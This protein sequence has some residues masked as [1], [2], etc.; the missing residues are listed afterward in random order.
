[1]AKPVYERVKELQNKWNKPVHDN[2]VER[3][4]GR[5]AAKGDTRATGH[6]EMSE[7]DT[8][9]NPGRDDVDAAQLYQDDGDTANETSNYEDYTKDELKEALSERD[10]PVSGSKSD[11]IARLEESD[12]ERSEE[13]DDEE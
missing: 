12:A 3:F 11:L 2:S 10:L 9:Q 5:P 7:L 8:D 13:D 6:V 1:M 4:T